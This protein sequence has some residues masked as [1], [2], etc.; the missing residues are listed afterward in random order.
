MEAIHV[1]FA[2]IDGKIK[3]MNCVNNGPAGSR[4]RKTGNFEAFES[5]RIPFARLH[6]SAFFYGSYGGEY[7][8]D[9]HRI[10]PNFDADEND[11][12][13]YIFEPTDEY[14]QDIESVGTKIFYRLGAAIEHG[15]KR[16]TYPPK[17]FLKWAKI[18]EHI[19]LH[20]TQ[21]WA[22][23]FYMDI[24]Y[25]EIWN[26]PDCGP[27]GNN[28]CW[29]G[30]MEEFAE[31][32]SIVATYLKE[33][34]PKLK[35]G[36]PAFAWV[37]DCWDVI[38]AYLQEKKVHLDFVSYHTYVSTPERFANAICEANEKFERF[39]YGNVEKIYNEWNY[40]KGWTGEDMKYSYRAIAG[41]KGSSLIT[42]C[43]CVAQSMDVDKLMYYDARP[44]AFNGLFSPY[45]LDPLKGYYSI[46]AFS[47]LA[48]FSDYVP[49]TQKEGL[50][51]CASTDGKNG[52]VLFTRYFDDD[53]V[54]SENVAL[55]FNG[56]SGK[57]KIAFYLLS[58]D[59]DLALVRE[60]IFE[61]DEWSGCLTL[62]NYE[63][64]L[65]KITAL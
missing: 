65:V 48:D 41:L 58:E 10:F 47:D 1:N 25:W 54:G 32:F 31:F 49:T 27:I 28:P 55:S 19:I 40:V 16:G 56:L 44:C 38:L 4:V 64:C 18:C 22:N 50:Y 21:G 43:M 52:C 51:S 14:L 12:S 20:Y 7:S 9:V 34:F 5:A 61:G 53:T 59:K 33:K 37:Q 42:A 8:V 46:K 29:Q 39:G 60:E 24:E 11:A 15:Y 13:N 63:S 2:K 35:I 45:T 23:G 17:D 62:N 36:G 6:D 57:S 30:T 26:E 3:P